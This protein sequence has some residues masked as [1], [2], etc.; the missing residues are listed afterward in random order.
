MMYNAI[1][2]DYGRDKNGNRTAHF[3]LFAPCGKEI[4]NSGKRRKQVGYSGYDCEAPLVALI[5]YTGEVYEVAK[6]SVN[7]HAITRV[8]FRKQRKKTSE[9]KQRFGFYQG[10]RV[11]NL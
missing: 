6:A 3:N 10:Y 5:E 2:Y 8:W 9:P 1:I 7:R 11:I 4:V